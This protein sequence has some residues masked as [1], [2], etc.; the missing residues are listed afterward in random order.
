MV[1]ESFSF[2]FYDFVL[3][4]QFQIVI[5][6]DALLLCLVQLL[7]HLVVLICKLTSQ[8]LQHL[9]EFLYACIISFLVLLGLDQLGFYLM[10][11]LCSLPLYV[12]LGQFVTL[13][14]HIMLQL[15]DHFRGLLDSI[16][17]LLYFLLY[18]EFVFV[19]LQLS[20]PA[21][22]SLELFLHYLDGYCP[23]LHLLLHHFYLVVHIRFL[24]ILFL[25]QVDHITLDQIV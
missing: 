1:F 14:V 10:D 24:L 5:D 11:F 9:L 2:G 22:Q 17:D 21:L 13:G 18:D 23:T 12:L 8:S 25:L 16:A 4:G 7:A 20:L 15:Q 3:L 6:A 19:L